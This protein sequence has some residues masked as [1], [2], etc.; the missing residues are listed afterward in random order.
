MGLEIPQFRCLRPRSGML[1]KAATA[2]SE[3][4]GVR[5]RVQHGC[6]NSLSLPPPERQGQLLLNTS[7]HATACSQANIAVRSS[8][9]CTRDTLNL[10]FVLKPNSPLQRTAFGGR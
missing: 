2:R 9:H 10:R 6:F 1:L 7:C 8:R 3:Q 4:S 5:K